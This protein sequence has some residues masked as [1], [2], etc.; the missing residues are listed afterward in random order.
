MLFLQ[1]IYYFLQIFVQTSVALD[2]LTF[3]IFLSPV[4]FGPRELKKPR[5]G[6]AMLIFVFL[7]LLTFFL[8]LCANSRKPIVSKT[9]TFLSYS[10]MILNFIKYVGIGLV[11]YSVLTGEPLPNG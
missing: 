6:F 1:L 8:S 9:Y 10:F 4:D 3:Y 5:F 2:V 11:Y 7:S